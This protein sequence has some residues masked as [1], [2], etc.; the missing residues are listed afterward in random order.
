MPIQANTFDPAIDSFGDGVVRMRGDIAYDGT[1]FHGWATQGKPEQ[2]RTVQDELEAALRLVLQ[3]P[4]LATVVA[5]RTDAGVHA[6]A[7]VFHV[8]VPL[9]ALARIR[10]TDES[11]T[12]K[13]QALY[14]RI[15]SLVKI[16]GDVYLNSL[17][18]V[19]ASFHAR[20]S[21]LSRQY[22][23]RIAD[24]L[25]PH[26]PLRRADTMWHRYPLDAEAMN[27]LGAELI[28][29]HD[30]AS[31]AIPKPHAT[32]IREVKEFS[33]ARDSDGVL[34]GNVVADAFCHHQV[35]FMV[36]AAVA[37]GQGVLTID[38]VLKIQ[39]QLQRSR[40]IKLMPA[41]GLTLIG[42]EYPAPNAFASQ[43][44]ITMAR[45]QLE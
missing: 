40:L 29:L 26:N 6:T 25:S 4:G 21:A 17:E 44:K 22:N 32:T 3:R 11:F 41:N 16:R 23:Y 28:G 45:R 19:P 13:V 18:P 2:L 27:T 10:G 9:A 43:A 34:V 7:Q 36:G 8:D 30:W 1:E 39:A 15:R 24:A 12:A 5:G 33:W 37:V 35:R 42:V 14:R 38:Q 31:F 20:F